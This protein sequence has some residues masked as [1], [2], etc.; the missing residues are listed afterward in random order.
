MFLTLFFFF[1]HE[2]S[3]ISL[4]NAKRSSALL[5]SHLLYSYP[6]QYLSLLGSFPFNTEIPSVSMGTIPPII[7]LAL[8]RPAHSFQ[9]ST[10]FTT[11]N[12]YGFMVGCKEPKPRPK[13]DPNIAQNWSGAYGSEPCRIWAPK[14][15]KSVFYTNWLD[16]PIEPD[17]NQ[18]NQWQNF[19]KIWQNVF[20][21]IRNPWKKPVHDSEFGWG[22]YDQ[23]KPKF[24][25]F[26]H[27]SMNYA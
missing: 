15:P 20:G 13:M 22:R 14:L 27:A 4:Q 17:S 10:C 6:S 23:N 24:S 5:S 21:R 18:S 7:S 19:L 25:E 3:I 12:P 16:E 8:T 2:Q 1:F 11:K 26:R 9:F